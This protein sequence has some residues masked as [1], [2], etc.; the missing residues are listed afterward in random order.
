MSIR[1]LHVANGTSVTMTLEAAGVPGLRS[2]WADPLNDG[3]V[4]DVPDEELLEV[5][6]RFLAGRDAARGNS[7]SVAA[8]P[9]N[10][11]RRW[12]DVIA[13]HHAYDELV[14]WFEHDLFD[15]LNLI[16]VL[17]W[18]RTNVPAAMTVSLICI[19]SFPGRPDFK[20]LG[21]LTA[22]ELAPLLDT[23]RPVT[24]A[25][26]AL[27]ERAWAAFRQPAP[28]ALDALRRADLS[29][30]PLLGAALTRLLEEYPWTTDGLS[31]SERRLLAL[32]GEG[33]V[34]LSQAFV[35]MGADDRVMTTTDLS[36]LD[37]VETLTHGSPPLMTLDVSGAGGRPFRGV[38]G[39][40]EAGQ[41]LR[42]GRLDRV[43]ACGIDRWIGGVHLHGHAG[44]WR[45]NPARERVERR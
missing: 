44:V 33:G 34:S 32:A 4:P 42:A 26:Y 14:L 18:I 16:Q 9:A 19:D 41:M 15:Q 7:G 6:R 3:P 36:L 24:A 38:I 17:T 43:S 37:T 27:A 22:A 35:R 25:Q 8:D 28:D 30:M 21:E 13:R 29:A 40:T 12:R 10:D 39:L 5:R 20:G 45:W 23:R 2:I 1:F 31:R 11:M